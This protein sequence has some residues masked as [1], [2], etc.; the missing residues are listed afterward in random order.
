M[1][2]LGCFNYGGIVSFVSPKLNHQEIFVILRKQR[3][4]SALREGRLRTSPHFYNTEEQI[5]T[6]LD[7]LPVN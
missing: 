2:V 1:S 6:L 4:E 7:A 3:F 5:D